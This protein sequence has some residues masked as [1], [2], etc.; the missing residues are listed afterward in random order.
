LQVFEN[1]D[2]KGEVF[3]LN[4][5]NTAELIEISP[6]LIEV[7]VKIVKPDRLIVNQNFD[8]SWTTNLGELDNDHGLISVKFDAPTDDLIRLE[9]VPKMFYFGLGLSLV[10]FLGVCY[11]LARKRK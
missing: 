10:S 7:K 6:D 1:P 4:A 3:F 9:Y 2:Y 11:L 5:E 8:S